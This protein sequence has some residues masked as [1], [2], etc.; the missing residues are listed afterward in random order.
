MKNVNFTDNDYN[1]LKI[2]LITT[3]FK[4]KKQIIIGM[5]LILAGLVFGILFLAVSLHSDFA[6]E[7]STMSFTVAMLGIAAIIYRVLSAKS[8]KRLKNDINSGFKLVGESEIVGSSTLRRKVFLA[9]QT[10]IYKACIQADKALIGDVLKYEKTLSG[11]SV[12][13]CEKVP[14]RKLLR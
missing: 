6:K 5:S 2:K 1:L 7:L 3:E 4:R 11:D 13:K 8:I 9:D 10:T 14:K 12:L